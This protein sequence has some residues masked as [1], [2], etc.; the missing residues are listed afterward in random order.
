V[1]AAVLRAAGDPLRIEDLALRDLGE[2]DV[3]VRIAASGVCHSDLSIQNGTI[4]HPLPAV[5]GHEGAGVVEEVGAA[6]QSV[7]VGDHVVLSWVAPCRRCYQCLH[8][9]PELCEHGLDHAFAQ[10]YATSD[11]GPVL[12]AFGTA[13]FGEQTV[14]PETA[15]VRI[16]PDFPLELGALVGCGVV[17][18]VGAVMNSAHVEPGA[19]VAVIGCGGVGLSALQGARL[20]GAQPIIAVDRVASKLELAR[21]NG[22]TDVVDASTTDPVT[23]VK[24][25][26]DGRGADYTFEVVGRSDTI[27]QAY[28]M[29]RRAGTVTIV[30]AGSFTDPV[31]FGAMNLMVEAKTMRGCVYGS[32]DPAR[33][34]PEMVRLHQAGKLDLTGLVSRRIALDDV[35]D[36]FR[37]MQAGEVARS[38]IV[39]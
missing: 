38:V 18:G 3:R 32:T 7:Q 24:E 36:A 11:A 26:T 17:T 2:H 31:E 9:H 34:F 27:R 35:D 30:G 28:D 1:K 29:A 16:D 21:A 5:L 20:A 23:A 12:A 6:V 33:D 19:S 13:T 10:P 22:A 15:C 8:G 37:A 14:L 39:F 4:P 25:C